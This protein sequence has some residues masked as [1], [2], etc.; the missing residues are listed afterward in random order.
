M[1]TPDEIN[2]L[3]VCGDEPEV[4]EYERKNFGKELKAYK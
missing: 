1:R 3:H 2:V 4:R